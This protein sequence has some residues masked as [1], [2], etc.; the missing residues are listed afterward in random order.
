MALLWGTL[1]LSMAG[2][3]IFQSLILAAGI[4]ISGWLIGGW[5]MSVPHVP[6]KSST[7]PPTTW[8]GSGPADLK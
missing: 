1:S 3:G 6:I 7:I 2:L 4:L 5:L 8:D